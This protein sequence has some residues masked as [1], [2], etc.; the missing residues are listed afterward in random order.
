M[1]GGASIDV[2][3][4]A[5]YYRAA[6]VAKSEW[7]ETVNTAALAVYASGIDLPAD[8]VLGEVVAN[9]A[10]SAGTPWVVVAASFDIFLAVA[11]GS[12]VTIEAP[13]A[14]SAVVVVVAVCIAGHA[15]PTPDDVVGGASQTDALLSLVAVVQS[16]HLAAQLIRVG[17]ALA[18]ISIVGVAAIDVAG[19]IG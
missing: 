15:P 6:V 11:V 18:A 4:A 3:L 2:V 7:A 19:I 5:A 1:A 9:R 17:A 13:C 10:L 14:E 8:V 12:V 16:A